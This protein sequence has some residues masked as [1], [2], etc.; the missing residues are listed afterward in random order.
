MPYGWSR[1]LLRL[2]CTCTPPHRLTC[3]AAIPSLPSPS[4]LQALYFLSS[5]FNQVRRLAPQLQHG[6]AW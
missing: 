2:G 1:P 3:A 4:P 6:A 5:F